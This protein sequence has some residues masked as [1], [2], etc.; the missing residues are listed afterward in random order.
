MSSFVVEL[1]RVG[2]LSLGNE[3]R[4]PVPEDRL[5]PEPELVED[6]A[7]HVQG[8]GDL[9]RRGTIGPSGLETERG[10]I[11]NVV[12]VDE[13]VED[14]GGKKRR[15]SSRRKRGTKEEEGGREG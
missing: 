4:R 7:G 11:G 12:H 9:E 3:E 10:E 15:K 8:M 2:F 5:V 6:V 14:L 1:V 13:I